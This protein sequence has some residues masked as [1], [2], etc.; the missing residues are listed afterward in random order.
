MTT[1]Q[2]PMK[3][4]DQ[5]NPLIQGCPAALDTGIITHPTEGKIGGVTVR[6]TSATVTVLL[7]TEDLGNWITVLQGLLEAMGGGPK[8]QAATMNDVAAMNGTLE[9]LHPSR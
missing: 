4:L 6:T 9:K 2:N 8:L 7:G 1:P 3:F 5:N